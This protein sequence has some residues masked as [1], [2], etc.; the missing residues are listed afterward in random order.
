MDTPMDRQIDGHTDGW[1]EAY[2]YTLFHIIDNYKFQMLDYLW[3]PDIY[4]WDMKQTNY[5]FVL[6]KIKGKFLN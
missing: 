3:L 5:I 4:V 1:A 2:C 6:D